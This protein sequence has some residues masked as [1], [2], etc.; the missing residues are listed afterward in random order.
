MHENEISENLR[1]ITH[2]VCKRLDLNLIFDVSAI[3][4]FLEIHVFTCSTLTHTY[5]DVKIS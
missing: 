5:I 3:Q 1:R 4:L 2:M